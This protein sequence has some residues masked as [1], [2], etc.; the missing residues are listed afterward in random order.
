MQFTAV[1]FPQVWGQ[2]EDAG[3]VKPQVEPDS[4]ARAERPRGAVVCWALEDRLGSCGL[5]RAGELCSIV[6]RFQP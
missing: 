1:V 2:Q 3:G 6:L 5:E 4:E